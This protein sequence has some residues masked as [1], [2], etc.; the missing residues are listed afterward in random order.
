MTTAAKFMH[1]V[2]TL[3]PEDGFLQQSLPSSALTGFLS[4][5]SHFPNLGRGGGDI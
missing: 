1:A 4:L 3:C 2:A 5:L